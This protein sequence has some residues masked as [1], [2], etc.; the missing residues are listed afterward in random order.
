M[1]APPRGIHNPAWRRSQRVERADEVKDLKGVCRSRE[2]A[3]TFGTGQTLGRQRVGQLAAE[4]GKRERGWAQGNCVAT[5]VSG[6]KPRRGKSPRGHPT[7]EPGQTPGLRAGSLAVCQTLKG[8]P[9]TS[10]RRQ[11]QEGIGAREGV[12]HR[13]GDESLGGLTPGAGPGWNKPGRPWGE[14]GVERVR[15]PEGAT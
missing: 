4:T 14:Q 5:T 10:V 8:S 3:A 15:N 9:S 11:P 7:K 1:E 2:R 12:R 13:R 6:K